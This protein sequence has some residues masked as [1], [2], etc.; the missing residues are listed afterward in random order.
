M[1]L[2]AFVPPIR[3]AGAAFDF[4]LLVPSLVLASFSFSVSDEERS[5]RLEL[6]VFRS[7]RS[8]ESS[9]S[10]APAI[11]VLF[12]LLREEALDSSSQCRAEVLSNA[13]QSSERRLSKFD[14]SN[15]LVI[16]DVLTYCIQ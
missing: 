3:C 11:E 15:L 13:W 9:S 16:D 12:P 5:D 8:T 2:S 1:V 14:Q 7:S 4:P 10:S 6:S